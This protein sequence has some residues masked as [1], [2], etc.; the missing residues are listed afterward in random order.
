MLVPVMLF[1][2]KPGFHVPCLQAMALLP[3]LLKG[4][5]LAATESS[6][7]HLVLISNSSAARC[8]ID[9]FKL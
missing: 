6:Q 7:P 3:T 2:A 8:A 4:V 9:L 1:R 5:T